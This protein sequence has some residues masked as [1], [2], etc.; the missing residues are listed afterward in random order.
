MRAGCLWALGALG[1]SWQSLA[2]QEMT[3]SLA[4]GAARV[5]FEAQPAFTSTTVSP[6]FT[7]R[8]ALAMV[9]GNVT[10]AQVGRAGWSTQGQVQAAAFTRASARG[11]VA[12]FA[13]SYGGSSF[14]AGVRTAQGLAA[15]R[16]HWLR[17]DLATW[18]GAAAGAM[19]DGAT[20][21]AVRQAE[22]GATLALERQ[23]L[24][25]TLTPSATDDTLRY[26]DWLALYGSAMAATDVTLSLGGRAGAALPIVGGDRRVWGSAQLQWWWRPRVALSVGAGSY[27]VDVTQGFPAGQYVSLGMRLGERRTHSATSQAEARRTRRAA[28]ASGVQDFEFRMADDVSVAIRVRADA[29][30]QVEITS[31]LTNWRPTALARGSDGW[32]WLRLPR[33]SQRV[34]EVAV[35]VNGGEWFAPPGTESLRDEFGGVSGRV[36]LDPQL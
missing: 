22:L 25:L 4:L 16:L 19:Y 3:A 27:P 12:E 11:L 14:P 5:A 8:S 35:R 33:G 2:A 31:D 26:T 9:S 15:A 30:A 34:V 7:F 13:G 29:A 20:W 21:R 36:V 24:S 23:R 1:L 10:F 18:L 6:G 17:G 28:R 32:W